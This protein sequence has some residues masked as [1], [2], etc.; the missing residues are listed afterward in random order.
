MFLMVGGNR[1]TRW[2]PTQTLGE[3]ANCKQTAAITT[4][5]LALIGNALVSLDL[6]L[7]LWEIRFSH[8]VVLDDRSNYR[9]SSTEDC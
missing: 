3:H 7:R 6:T 8:H 9:A 2:K 5:I 1:S 4:Y